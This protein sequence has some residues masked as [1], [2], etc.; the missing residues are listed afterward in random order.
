M[1]KVII[2]IRRASSCEAHQ[3]AA[4]AFVQSEMCFTWKDCAVDHSAHS[5]QQL[6]LRCLVHTP[7]CANTKCWAHSKDKLCSTITEQHANIKA[8]NVEHIS[9]QI[10]LRHPVHSVSP[11]PRWAFCLHTIKDKPNLGSSTPVDHPG[12]NICPKV[13]LS[14]CIQSS[15][16]TQ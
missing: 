1:T 5:V 16:S 12:V 6:V 13:N 2:I 3:G 8:G 15:A 11:A 9:R 10:L 7:Q 4:I 14:Y